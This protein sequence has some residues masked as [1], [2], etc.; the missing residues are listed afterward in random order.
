MKYNYIFFNASDSMMHK[1]RNG[2]F[3]ICV[4]DLEN[5][6]KIQIVSAPMDY[7]PT[8]VR[9]LFRLHHIRRFISLPF[10][11][12]WY[13]FYFRNP[14]PNH[15]PLCFILSGTTWYPVNYI[16]YLKRKYPKA[17]IVKIHR[18][19]IHLWHTWS[20][21]YTEDIC[22][23]LFDLRLSF[24]EE[25]AKKYGA[26]F[27][28]EFESKIDVPLAR[29]YPLSD[30]FFAGKAKDRLPRIM[31]AYKIF[32]GVGLK[33]AYY[34]TGVPEAERRSLP[35]VTYA[36]KFMTY[37]EMLYRTIN[38]RC[39]L[40]INQ[41]GAVGYTSRFLEAVMYNKKLI[42][43]NV[44]IRNTKFYD[45][46][47]IQC[48]DDVHDIRPEFVTTDVG[49][50]DYHYNNEFSPIHLIEQIDEELIKLDKREGRL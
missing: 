35:G 34:L 40:E 38:S 43:D 42:T 4:A 1:S 23:E 24:D 13:P 10:K 20:P 37:R 36:D 44:T 6:P 15:E 14:F 30:V 2:Y 7:T 41:G 9:A 27:F 32:T 45:P 17:R 16:R 22:E 12:I 31:E 29:D 46:R 28:N 8:F 50:V 5:N 33:C 21:E 25:E 3:S 47:Y 11:D 49:E 26:I 39:V 48:V 18:D 19:L